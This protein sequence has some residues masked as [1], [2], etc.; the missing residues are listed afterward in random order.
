MT[1]IQKMPFEEYEYRVFEGLP[2]STKVRYCSLEEV[3]YILSTKEG[4]IDVQELAY[5]W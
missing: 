2:Q 5:T 1:T 4:T 3:L